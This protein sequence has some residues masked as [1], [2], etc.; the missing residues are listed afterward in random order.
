[1]IFAKILN[2]LELVADFF[3]IDT[4]A[5]MWDENSKQW[6]HQFRD[7]V[8]NADGELPY[9]FATENVFDKPPEPERICC[10]AEEIKSILATGRVEKEQRKKTDR[11]KNPPPNL[12]K[13]LEEMSTALQARLQ[14]GIRAL[15]AKVDA[16][17]SEMDTSITASVTQ[18][19]QDLRAGRSG[20]PGEG[21]REKG[22][23]VGGVA[24]AGMAAAGA[25]DSP[26]Q[27]ADGDGI[28]ATASTTS[29]A[30]TVAQRRISAS[31]GRK[32]L[33]AGA[34]SAAR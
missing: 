10:T 12:E 16:L 8:D 20:S 22:I 4:Y 28:A 15:E 32:P 19:S 31:Q 26:E 2:R 23:S 33:G 13:A 11:S 7:I 25:L 30:S 3:G 5:G 27:P 1:M 6:V 21:S 17:K 34:K 14:T 29:V 24:A 9:H 18:L